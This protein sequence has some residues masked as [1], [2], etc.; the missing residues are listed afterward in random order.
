MC[1]LH[2]DTKSDRLLLVEGYDDE[3][4]FDKLAAHL[5]VRGSFHI[6]RCGG[7]TRLQE[8]L[9]LALSDTNFFRRLKHVA[10]VRDADQNTDAFSSAKSAFEYANDNGPKDANETPLNEY[11]IPTEPFTRT[12][13]TP[14]TSVLILPDPDESGALEN[15]VIKALK[16]D[17]LWTCVDKYFKC[18]KKVGLNTEEARLAK[19]Q[20]GVFISG[21]VVDPEEATPRDSRRKLLSDIYRL[22]WW[23][24]NN[25]WNDDAFD[26]AKDFLQQLL[27]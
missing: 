10:I 14:F 4:F 27:D 25:L 18:A 11:D 8:E 5:E 19:S 20:I 15:Y 21:K 3:V 12:T 22:K 13:K 17:D 23:N 1:D 24:D 2:I 9:L 6:V 16:R 26:E 7:V